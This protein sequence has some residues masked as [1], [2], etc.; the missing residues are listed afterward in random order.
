VSDAPKPPE[1]SHEPDQDVDEPP[2]D[3]EASKPVP[4]RRGRTVAMVLAAVLGT[5][6]VLCAGG[7]GAAYF[8][9][10]R[11]SEPDRST[12][13]VVVRQYL[14]ATLNDRDDA[15]SRLFTCR[16]ATGL[17]QVGQLRDDIKSREAQFGV[18]IRTSPEG[19]DT[20]QSGNNANVEVKIRLSVAANGTFQE[21][22]QNW[23]FALKNESGWRVCAGEPIA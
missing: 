15:R 1:P 22:I 7:I 16:N 13:G 5:L 18:T 11:A 17:A 10:Q 9:Y 12:P 2:V 3:A 14:E 20:Q 6:T 23:R 4:G 19:F 8:F 21:Q